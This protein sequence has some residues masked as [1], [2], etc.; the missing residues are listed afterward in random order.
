MPFYSINRA[1]MDER[2]FDDAAESDGMVS[3]PPLIVTMTGEVFQPVRLYYHVHDMHMVHQIFQKMS[4]MD[5]DE[6]NNRW[7]WLYDGEAR[8][9]KFRKSYGSI[10]KAMRPIVLGSFYSHADDEMHLDI[11]SIERA[12]KAV[13]FFDKY[14]GRSV[15]E[16]KHVAIYNKLFSD[17]ADHPGS[18]FD[19]L[20]SDVKAEE[21]DART[22]AKIERLRE[23]V[24]SGGLPGIELEP[25]FELVE[26]FPVNFYEEGV[27]QLET[28]LQMRQVVAMQRWRGNE[29][30][31]LEDVVKTMISH[32]HQ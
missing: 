19:R 26:A 31:S 6:A 7:A 5:F 23:A 16:V 20:F 18:N 30:F 29:D 10:P 22:E 25:G 27:Q 24:K 3:Q 11:G 4:C 1:L 12:T 8:P 21:I 15:A 17:K 13:V 9:L 32:L 2:S 28:S 14:I